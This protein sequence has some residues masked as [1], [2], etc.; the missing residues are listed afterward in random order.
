MQSRQ[1]VVTVVTGI[2][3]SSSGHRYVTGSHSLSLSAVSAVS[4][5]LSWQLQLLR[6]LTS[7][8]K[9]MF[10]KYYDLACKENFCIKSLTKIFYCCPVVYISWC[11]DHFIIF[12]IFYVEICQRTEIVMLRSAERLVP[13]DWVNFG[14]NILTSWS[15]HVMWHLRRKLRPVPATFICKFENFLKLAIN[16]FISSVQHPT[17]LS[18][19]GLCLQSTW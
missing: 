7:N 16:I 14:S 12:H 6:A 13:A 10:N 15:D 1:W 8:I 3:W 5:V 4:A 19:A 18:F 11:L 2:S 17:I 9:T